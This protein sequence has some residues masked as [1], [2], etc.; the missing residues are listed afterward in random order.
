MRG[1]D[2]PDKE[3][4]PQAAARPPDAYTGGDKQAGVVERR[5]TEPSLSQD[6]IVP[7]TQTSQ[8]EDAEMA[9]HQSVT[10]GQPDQD[11]TGQQQVAEDE[12]SGDRA[13]ASSSEATQIP[14]LSKQQGEPETVA[15]EKEMA[16]IS[17]WEMFDAVVAAM[18]EATQAEPKVA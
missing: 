4:P 17:P 10:T 14:S 7:E 18:K 5:R 16:E 11:S 6:S 3:K 12:G 1:A 2:V 8:E 15:S 13:E 9:E